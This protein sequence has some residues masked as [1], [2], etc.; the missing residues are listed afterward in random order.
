MAENRNIC[1]MSERGRDRETVCI[2]TYRVLDS[3]RDKD[4][5]EDVRVYLTCGGQEIIDRTAAV[6]VKGARVLWS[7]IDIDNVPFNRGFYQLTVKIYVKIFCEACLGPGNSEEFDGVAVL[8]KKAVLFGSEGNVSI[9]KSEY[10]NNGFCCSGEKCA[11]ARSSNLPVAVLETVD[12]IVLSSKVVEP[13]HHCH[14]CCSVDEVPDVVCSA[15]SGDLA[16]GEDSNKLV[17]TLGLFSVLR[18]E[19]PAQYL[20]SASEFSVPDKEC[21]AGTDN[22]PCKLF[23]SMEFPEREF[24]VPSKLPLRGNPDRD[25]KKCGCDR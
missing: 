4:C 2:D 14:C 7:Y 17:V 6:R 13:R 18:I 8:E 22:D 15:V 21:V 10:Q 20:V 19:R 16:D 12:P 25:D 11:A 24:S 23:M 9:F 5:F 1:P 3:C